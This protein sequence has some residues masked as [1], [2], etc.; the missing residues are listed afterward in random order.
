MKKIKINKNKK[1]FNFKLFSVRFI[2]KIGIF[3]IIISIITLKNLGHTKTTIDELKPKKTINNST[4][5][6]KIAQFILPK[7]QEIYIYEDS[8]LYKYFGKKKNQIEIIGYNSH[9][10]KD[11]VIPSKI[12]GKPVVSI[13]NCAFCGKGLTSVSIPNSVKFID[14]EAFK[15]NNLTQLV[16]PDNVENLGLGAFQDNKL[17]KV[18]FG[19]NITYID[20]SVFWSNK[21]K[22]VILPNKTVVNS[23]FDYGV[24]VDR[25]NPFEYKE[26][27]NGI[28]ITSYRN[29]SK[30]IIIPS[31]IYGKKVV[32]I[33]SEAFYNKHLDSVVIPD[34]IE[35]IH[36]G[37][38]ME[39]NLKELIL[40][41]SVKT[42]EAHA[43]EHNF[44]SELILGKNI[45]YIE[46]SA[47]WSNELKEVKLPKKTIINNSFDY[48]VNLSR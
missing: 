2:M 13:G 4:K 47:F 41:N 44:I 14:S 28:E 33:G 15:E 46:P 7:T 16:I 31:E 36:T 39:N 21:L 10:S 25:M 48:G 22:E 17:K 19:N 18:E 20:R 45:D 26:L 40:P 12:E 34:T 42:I 23:S 35:L 9:F 8:F 3:T 30:N 11:V 24:I 6:N 1:Y 38:F 32:S 5:E 37:A 27:D 43:F 29:H